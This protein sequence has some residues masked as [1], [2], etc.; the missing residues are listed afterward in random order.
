MSSDAAAAVKD[1]LPI[2]ASTDPENT[3]SA[4]SMNQS[5][6]ESHALAVADHDEKGAAQEDH[7]Q[8]VL[9]TGWNE[10]PRYIANPLIGGIKN[11]DLWVLIRRFNK[12]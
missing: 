7:D 11:D 2:P 3:Y 5:P 10:D 4:D 12:V 9:D 6:T 8:E 1:L